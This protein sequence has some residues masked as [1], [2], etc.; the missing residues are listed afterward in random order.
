[1]RHV[2]RLKFV[3][4]LFNRPYLESLTRLPLT[5]CT[6]K[7]INNQYIHAYQKYCHMGSKFEER[8]HREICMFLFGR[9][10]LFSGVSPTLT[11]LIF[12]LRTPLVNQNHIH[13]NQTRAMRKRISKIN[14]RSFFLTTC[15][16]QCLQDAICQ[17]AVFSVVRY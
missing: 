16:I 1:M 8:K 6:F 7:C 14:G 2:C 4:A 5:K 15:Y 11:M 12:S 17:D 3:M 10:R 9:I 13:V